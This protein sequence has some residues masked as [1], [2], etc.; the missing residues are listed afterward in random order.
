[1]MQRNDYERELF[2]GDQGLVLRVAEPGAASHRFMAVFPR[3]ET[4][5][6]FHLDTLRSD[7]E[8]SYATTVHKAQGSEYDCVGLLLP[9]TDLPLLTREL[10]YTALTRS[11]RS[12]VILGDRG[13][14]E[15][16][17]KARIRRSSGIGEKLLREA[18]RPEK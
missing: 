1:M 4:F 18:G 3:G 12:V 16:A 14:L 7:L 8:L 6:A 15:T 5:A 9:E 13:L 17:A 2:N 10:L 11:R